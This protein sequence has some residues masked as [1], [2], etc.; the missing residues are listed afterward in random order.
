MESGSLL[1]YLLFEQPWPLI[2]VGLVLAFLVWIIAGRVARFG[3]RWASLALLALAVGVWV[4]A[5]VVD[6]PREQ[7]RESTRTLIQATAAPAEVEQFFALLAPDMTLRGPDGEVWYDAQEVRDTLAPVL[8]RYEVDAQSIHGLQIEVQGEDAARALLQLRTEV[9]AYGLSART[10]WILT[11]RRGEDGA[12]RLVDM[13]WLRV[14][15]RPPERGI[16]SGI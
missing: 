13:Q 8:R 16:W 7:V 10:R 12:W 2:A 11:W 3:W 15:G 4:L 1:P 6:T 5:W 14:Q 9:D